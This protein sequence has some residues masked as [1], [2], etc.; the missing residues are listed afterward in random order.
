MPRR[1]EDQQMRA[2]R[3][4]ASI[5]AAAT[6]TACANSLVPDLNNA[7][8][9]GFESSPTGGAAGAIAV[10]LI[11]GA[12]DNTGNM[13]WN[14]G[15]FGR[16]GYEMG[17]AQGDL[18]LYVDGP[19]NPGTFYTDLMWDGQYADIRAANTVLDNLARVPDLTSTQK[20]AL[21]G[22]IQTMEAYDLI[23]LAA[24]RD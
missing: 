10:G 4:A 9:N 20:S 24:T 16:E 12:R 11:R 8:I 21:A 3:R 23:Q 5:A 1:F 19:V 22:F 7:S 14:V 17:V 6:L 13:A 15:A 18:T 2:I